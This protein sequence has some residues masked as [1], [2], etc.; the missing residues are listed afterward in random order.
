VKLY[1]REQKT[2]HSGGGN[3]IGNKRFLEEKEV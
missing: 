3:F 1:I 2:L